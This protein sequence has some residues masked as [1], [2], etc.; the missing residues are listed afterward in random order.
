[1]THGLRWRHDH[2]L[3]RR[4]RWLLHFHRRRLPQSGHVVACVR[5]LRT[6]R[7]S[8]IAYRAGSRGLGGSVV[9]RCLLKRKA[10][11]ARHRLPGAVV[12]AFLHPLPE[13]GHTGLARVIPNRR[14]LRDRIGLHREHT[15]PRPEGFFENSLLTRELEPAGVEDRRNAT[16]APA[17]EKPVLRLAAIAGRDI[18][19][20]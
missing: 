7:S 9:A 8:R 13:L 10:Y 3:V 2:V 12:S 15:R 4:V 11:M 16:Q 17:C 18:R 19:H 20:S 5:G 1:M 14:R 6:R